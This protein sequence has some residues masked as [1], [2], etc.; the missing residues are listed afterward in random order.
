MKKIKENK[1]LFILLIITIISFILGILYPA[2]LNEK[3]KEL[4]TKT[5]TEN[6]NNIKNINYLKTLTQSFINNIPLTIII[7]LLG[8]SIIGIPIIIIILILKPF[9]A[10]FTITS[11]IITKGIKSLYIALIYTLPNILNI[12]G[13]ILLSYYALSFSL[14]LYK[15]IFKKKNITFHN[16]IKNYI[17]LLLIFIIYQTII[18]LIETYLIPSLLF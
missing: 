9:I 4:I 3:D 11:I 14:T 8:I 17:K 15:V 6:L 2:I 16:I 7:W 10:G 5:I 1:L 13:S 12:I 18:T